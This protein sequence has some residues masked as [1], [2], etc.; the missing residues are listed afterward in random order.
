MNYS[1]ISADDS[2]RVDPSA[3]MND[4]IKQVFSSVAS[5]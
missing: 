1:L 5:Y 4:A 2:C 3:K